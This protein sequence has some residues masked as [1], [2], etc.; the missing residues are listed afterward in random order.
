MIPKPSDLLSDPHGSVWFIAE[1]SFFHL[2]PPPDFATH[3]P[4]PS[5]FVGGVASG[6]G[7][8]ELATS[9]RPLVRGQPV[10]VRLAVGLRLSPMA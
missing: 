8:F 7:R 3:F 9:L 1:R 2:S 5:V 6:S 10:K 4:V